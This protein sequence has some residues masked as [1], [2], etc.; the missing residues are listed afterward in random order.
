MLVRY[1]MAEYP[2]VVAEDAKLSDALDIMHT[3]KVRRLPVMRGGDLVGIIALS[4]LYKPSEH[5]HWEMRRVEDIRVAEVMTP[6]PLTCGRNAPLEEVGALMRKNRIGAVPVLDGNK[7]VGIITESDILG[8]LVSVAK[9]GSDGSRICFRIPISK[10]TEIFYEIVSLCEKNGL[11]ILTLLTHPLRN[12]DHL[13]M[14]RV[15]GAKAQDFID[16]LWKHHYEV[17]IAASKES[18]AADREIPDLIRESIE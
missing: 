14:L 18:P 1:W 5:V 7:L 2:R 12:A 3:Y 16:E 15:R 9:A 13:V 11:E 8:A 10:K 4:D 17:L 6:S